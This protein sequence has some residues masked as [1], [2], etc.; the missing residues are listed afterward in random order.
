M[1]VERGVDGP[2]GLENR[3]TTSTKTTSGYN[4]VCRMASFHL[5]LYVDQTCQV[6]GT[7]SSHF[8][9]IK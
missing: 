7:A 2:D 6:L 5:F 8:D 3:E 9:L 4:T 1:N